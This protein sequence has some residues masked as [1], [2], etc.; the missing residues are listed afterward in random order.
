[1][2][3]T[4]ATISFIKETLANLENVKRENTELEVMLTYY[5]YKLNQCNRAVEN[6]S[7]GFRKSVYICIKPDEATQKPVP[8]DEAIEILT[9][10]VDDLREQLEYGKK[11][12]E[13]LTSLSAKLFEVYPDVLSE[14]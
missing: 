4:D 5:E 12:Q 8:L 13:V 14:L 10:K 11:R 9:K 6:L 2:W 1:M 3:F 7:D